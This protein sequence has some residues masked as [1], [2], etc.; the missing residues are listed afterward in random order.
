MGCRSAACRRRSVL[1]ASPWVQCSYKQCSHCVDAHAATTCICFGRQCQRVHTAN[2]SVH[3]RRP[4]SLRAQAATSCTRLL[5]MLLRGV[6]MYL[7]YGSKSLCHTECR[8]RCRCRRKAHATELIEDTTLQRPRG[9]RISHS[10]ASTSQAQCS[11]KSISGQEGD[12]QW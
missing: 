1:A 7:C 3:R 8:C 4:C 12:S 10:L 6:S 9:P 11:L 2:S 5:D